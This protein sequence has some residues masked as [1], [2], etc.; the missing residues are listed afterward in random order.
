MKRA[1]FTLVGATAFALASYGLVELFAAWY[2][3]RFVRSDADIG[4]AFMTALAFMAACLIAGGYL[5]Y[6]W[7]GRGKT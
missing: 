7:A 2:G 6:R 4:K 5:G 3:P 1:L